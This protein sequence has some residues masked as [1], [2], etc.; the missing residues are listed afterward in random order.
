MNL[1]DIFKAVQEEDILT[2]ET[3]EKIGANLGRG[4]AGLINVFNPQLVVLGGKVARTEP[5]TRLKR[6][7]FSTGLFS[8]R[9]ERVM[10]EMYRR[11]KCIDARTMKMIVSTEMSGEWK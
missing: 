4:L 10:N 9:N 11:P 1:N 2:I 7:N 8:G 3:I 6:K 5:P